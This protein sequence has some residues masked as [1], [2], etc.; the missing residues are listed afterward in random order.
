M[1]A[2]KG[3]GSGWE[4]RLTVRAASDCCHQLLTYY[5]PGRRWAAAGRAASGKTKVDRRTPEERQCTSGGTA[6]RRR[7][8]CASMT[9]DGDGQCR[10]GSE[11]G[12]IA[13]ATTAACNNP[14]T[15]DDVF[16]QQSGRCGGRRQRRTGAGVAVRRIVPAPVPEGVVIEHELA[17]LRSDTQREK[18]Q[19]RFRAD[20][21][22]VSNPGLLLLFFASTIIR[23]QRPL[24]VI[25]PTAE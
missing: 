23:E 15:M 22:L 7:E 1:P 19:R 5:D 2:A 21:E 16:I 18:S 25:S 14:L 4:E 8:T 12:S 3:R 9:M 20:A 24:R 10:A 6:A 13:G 11:A 17:R